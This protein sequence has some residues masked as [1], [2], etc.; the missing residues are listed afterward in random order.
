[1]KFGLKSRKILRPNF[2]SIIIFWGFLPCSMVNLFPHQN[3]QKI[4]FEIFRIEFEFLKKQILWIFSIKTILL[5][6]LLKGHSE[7]EVF[8][9]SILLA[10]SLNFCWD[11]F[12]QKTEFLW[13]SPKS[14]L[15]RLFLSVLKRVLRKKQPRMIRDFEP[16]LK[17]RTFGKILF[18]GKISLKNSIISNSSFWEFSE[19]EIRSLFYFHGNSFFFLFQ[20]EF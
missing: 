12:F 2:K 3:I 5:T 20:S 14:S 16:I 4:D 7:L 6:S 9:S 13:K 18:N 17:F 10:F 19:G 15:D 11:S 1:M 8:S